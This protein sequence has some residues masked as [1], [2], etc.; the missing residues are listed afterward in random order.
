MMH[1]NSKRS[2]LLAVADSNPKIVNVNYKK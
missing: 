2:G 1:T